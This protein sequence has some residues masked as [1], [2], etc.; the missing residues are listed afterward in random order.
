MRPLIGITTSEV[1]P[2]EYANQAPVDEPFRAEM[3]LG[4]TY[5]NAIEVAGGAPVVLPPLGEETI[6]SLLDRLDAVCLSGGPDLD[7]AEYGAERDPQLGPT[8]R[9][10]DRFEL[11]LARAADRRGV[12]ILGICRGSQVLN[13]A[14]GGDLIQHLTIGGDGAESPLHHRQRVPGERPT[15]EIEIVPG[16]VLADAIGTTTLNV[17]S[18]HHQAVN[19]LGDGLLAS[20]HAPDGVV[21]AIEDPNAAL[22]LGVQWH[23]EYDTDRATGIS[24][25]RAL[26]DAAGERITT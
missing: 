8:W 11:A 5:T 10:L 26:V 4:I 23:A 16:S 21:E 6:D 12:P 17:N 25:L 15:H 2:L 19:R 7:P 13:V 1:R 18:F 3:A 14:R 22:Y 24:L 9:R 20:A